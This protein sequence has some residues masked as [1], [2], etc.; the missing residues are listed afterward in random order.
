MDIESVSFTSYCNSIAFRFSLVN[1]AENCQLF[2]APSRTFR[3]NVVSVT[4]KGEGYSTTSNSRHFMA[5]SLLRKHQI[6]ML[7]L[8]GLSG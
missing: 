5:V 1:M 2:F 8:A 4:S 6:V 7:T 3:K